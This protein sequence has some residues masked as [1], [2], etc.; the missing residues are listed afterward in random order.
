LSSHSLDIV[1]HRAAVFSFD[2][3]NLISSLFHKLYCWCCMR[4]VI[5]MLTVTEGFSC[6]I[7]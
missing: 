1:F 6:V 5:G 4:K 3:V 7:F 2:E